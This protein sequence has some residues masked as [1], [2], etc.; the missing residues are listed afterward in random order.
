MG[1]VWVHGGNHSIAAGIVQVSGELIPEAAENISPVHEFVRCDGLH[2]VRQF[3]GRVLAP[4]TRFEWAA[5]FEV[6][7]VMAR[8][9]VLQQRMTADFAASPS[10]C[11]GNGELGQRPCLAFR[12]QT[13]PSRY[14]TDSIRQWHRKRIRE[15]EIHN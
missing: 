15:S 1:I 4:V 10:F 12:C 7:R 8:L 13:V 9:G 2:F 14:A 11:L 5:I 6:G 3:D